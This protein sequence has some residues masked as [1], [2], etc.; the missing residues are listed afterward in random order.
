MYLNKSK[1]GIG[2]YSVIQKNYSGEK[3][4]KC[5]FLNFIFKKGCE[6]EEESISGD[7]FFVDS[8]GKKRLVLPYV[9]DF[10][11]SRQIKFRLMDELHKVSEEDKKMMG[12]AKSDS[13]KSLDINPDDL[14]FY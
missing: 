5:E 1:R 14:P 12:G 11:G 6:P 10:N 13:G 7:L 9:D 8:Y 2:W 3:M 4:E